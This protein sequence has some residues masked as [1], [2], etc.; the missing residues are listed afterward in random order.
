MPGNESSRPQY[1]VACNCGARMTLDARSFGVAR[2]C[3]G[4]GGSVVV[5]WGRDPST[6]QTVP[7]A[8]TR[9][10]KPKAGDRDFIGTCPCGYSRPVS[11]SEQDKKPRCSNCGKVMNVTIARAEKH[12]SKPSAPLIPLYMRPKVALHSM[13]KKDARFFDCVCGLRLTIRDGAQGQTIT[14]P[15]C[16]RKHVV[17]AEAAPAPKPRPAASPPR[18]ASKPRTQAPPPP[19]PPPVPAAPS[20]PLGMGEFLCACGDIQ[21]PRT[22]R[23]GKEFTCKKC[24]RKGSVEMDKDPKTG[25]VVMRPVFKSGPTIPE[26]PPPSPAPVAASDEPAAVVSFEML[27][28]MEA[29]MFEQVAGSNDGDAPPLV[30]ADA[31]IAPCECGAELLLSGNDV[32]RT[33]Q[34]PA[35]SDTLSIELKGGKFRLRLVS[36]L[37]TTDWK[38]DEFQ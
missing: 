16:D 15:D 28:P 11:A 35:C 7:V 10:P 3:R 14:C 18:P 19:P 2:P 22:S 1:T 21:P 34:C 31:Q 17:E 12:K 4:C 8:V 29:P 13:V 24:G 38:L 23:T 33:I 6:R 25:V 5:A 37:E 27:S 20:R 36:G 9:P 30:Q 32:G 26:A